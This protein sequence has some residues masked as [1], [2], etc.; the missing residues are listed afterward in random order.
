[1]LTMNQSGP[2][3]VLRLPARRR[4]A[5]GTSIALTVALGLAGTGT[6]LAL[7]TAQHYQIAAISRGS[8]PMA[9]EAS[10]TLD[11]VAR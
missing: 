6:L 8:Q 11:S 1:M 7:N 3:S 9:V 2:D 10:L 4:V 5:L